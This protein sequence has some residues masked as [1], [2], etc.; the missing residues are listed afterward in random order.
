VTETSELWT[1]TTQTGN[2]GKF[3][4]LLDKICYNFNGVISLDK[5]NI[6]TIKLVLLEEQEQTHKIT[7][8]PW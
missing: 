8:M 2:P 4:M 3:W 7:T 1:C 6:G 5:E